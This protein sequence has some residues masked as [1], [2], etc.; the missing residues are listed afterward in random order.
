M[1]K[2]GQNVQD[3]EENLTKVI[4]AKGRE[5]FEALQKLKRDETGDQNAKLNGWDRMYWENIQK[6]KFF[7]VDEDEIKQYF[8]MKNVVTETLNIYQELLGLNFTKVEGNQVWHEDVET[9]EVKDSLS[10]ELLGHFYLDLFPR[11]GKFNHAAVFPMVKRACFGEGVVP[12]AAAMVCNFDKPTAD[13]ESTLMHND[14]VTFFHEF[15]HVMHN[16]CTKG[17]FSRFSGTS[18]ERDFVE[19][20]SQMLEN[21]MWNEEILARV[22]KHVKT[23]EPLPQ[24]LIKKKLAIKNLNEAYFT[25]TQLFYGTFDLILHSASD[26]VLL[27][28]QDDA[29][30]VHSI[31]RLRQQLKKNGTKVDTMALWHQLRP[32]FSF[33]EQ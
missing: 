26:E 7:Q 24:E 12:S 15:G 28:A 11:D 6:Q 17:N 5:E 3:F 4:L 14:V 8:P 13:S 32:V 16:I 1:A 22:S 18:V 20:P 2:T 23:G 33:Y 25:L 29:N 9:Y 21:W 10:N 19:M 30:S 31:T 27:A